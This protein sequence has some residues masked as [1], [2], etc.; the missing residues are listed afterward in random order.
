MIWPFLL[1][2]V[3][4][5]STAY[6]H[7]HQLMTINSI[8]GLISSIVVGSLLDRFGRKKIVI[9]GIF[10]SALI[11]LGYISANQYWQFALLMGASGLF[12]PLQRVG[13]SAMIADLF[14]GNQR[15]Q[16][17]ALFRTAVNIGFGSGPIIGVGAQDLL[18]W[19][20]YRLYRS[21]HL[22]HHHHDIYH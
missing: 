19:F 2:F 8:T 13:I 3:A 22:G 12:G 5:G 17:Y 4:A 9:I 11:Y 20:D 18:L 15:R 14:E 6:G 16:A 7:S 1:I 10:G 21:V